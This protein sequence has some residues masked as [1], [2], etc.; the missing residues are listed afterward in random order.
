[1]KEA[2]RTAPPA[3]WEAV[4]PGRFIRTI[5][6]ERERSV[7]SIWSTTNAISMTGSQGGKPMD[8]PPE[9]ENSTEEERREY[10]KRCYPCLADCDMCGL[11]K[12]FHGKDPENAYRD[13]IEGEKSFEEVTK[14][15]DV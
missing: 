3:G 8:R 15:R 10:I 9:I 12:V 2:V 5:S 13:Y 11:C 7:R 6:T 1:M 4:T 14:G